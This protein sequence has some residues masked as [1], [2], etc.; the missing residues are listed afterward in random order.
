MAE[1]KPTYGNFSLR[2]QVVWKDRQNA[3]VEDVTSSGLEYR[4]IRFGVKTSEKNIV[5]VELFGAKFD[6]ITLQHIESKKRD[7]KVKY[8]EHYDLPEGYQLFM[9]VRIGLEQ[10]ENGNN[11]KKEM[12]SY[13][14]VKYINDNLKD[15]DTVFVFG[16]LR[17]SEY[18]NRNGETIPQVTFEIRGIYHAS[19]KYDD[20]EFEGQSIFDQQIILK[21]TQKKDNRLIVNSYIV[22]DNKGNFTTHNF[23]IDIDK[24]KKFARNVHTK[25]KFG[26]ILNVEGYI[27][28]TVEEKEVETDDAWGESVKPKVITN[29]IKELEI[30]AAQKPSQ[31]DIGYYK[32]EDFVKQDETEDNPFADDSKDDDN[33]WGDSPDSL[34]NVDFD[35]D[36]FNS[37]DDPFA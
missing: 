24:Y 35:D 9:P 11:I 22:T 19:I 10:D 13:D 32:E 12:I 27:H 25:L 36:P 37:D 33:D 20:E 2:G 7:K 18:V 31:E 15:G 30:T 5:Q 16:S 28:H 14:A 6:E 1:L 34:D 23:Y 4:R 8:G 26:T 17:F 29:I 3:Y 21:S